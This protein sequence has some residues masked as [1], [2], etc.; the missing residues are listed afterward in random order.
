MS[1]DYKEPPDADERRMC[2][3]SGIDMGWYGSKAMVDHRGYV[4][5]TVEYVPIAMGVMSVRVL[6]SGVMSLTLFFHPSR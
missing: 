5:I 6:T 2:E 1:W 4:P 3:H